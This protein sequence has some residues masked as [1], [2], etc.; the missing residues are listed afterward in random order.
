MAQLLP[1]PLRRTH[2]QH[3]TNFGTAVGATDADNTDTLTYSLSGTD[4]GSFGIDTS[5]GQLKTSV[6]LDYEM[7]TSYS[8]T[9]GVSDGT[10][11]DS[12]TVT[13]NVTNVNE[14]PAFPAT[15]ATR[16]VA[17]NTAANTNIGA[18]VAAT[19]PDITATNT[20]A[21]PGDTTADAL[22]YSLSGTDAAS[23]DIVSTSGQL[24][25]KAALDYE[26]KTS[27]TV[28][29]TASD[30]ALSDTITVTINVIDV[31]ET[32]PDVPTA[33]TLEIVSGD[34]QSSEANQTLRNSLVVVVKDQNDDPLP[35][36][37]VEFSTAFDPDTGRSFGTVSPTTDVT[38]ADGQASTRLTLGRT[39]GVY[40]VKASVDGIAKTVT[41][42]ANATGTLNSKNYSIGKVTSEPINIH[43]GD[44]VD[45]TVRVSPIPDEEISAA[46]YVNFYL[47]SFA[48]GL[49]FDDTFKV[50]IPGSDNLYTYQTNSNGEA[51]ARLN[52]A[53]DAEIPD[54]EPNVPGKSFRVMVDFL[55]DNVNGT[56]FFS[57]GTSE[58]ISP[59]PIS[60]IVRVTEPETSEG[61][62]VE[63]NAGEVQGG[64]PQ[65]VVSEVETVEVDTDA[66]GV[67]IS[68][69]PSGVQTGAFEVTV[70]FTEAVTGFAQEDLSVTGTA[71]AIITAWV[72]YPDNTTYTAMITPT[73]SGK[74]VL[75][76]A[77][78]V[79]TDAADNP[80]TASETQT[81]VI[82]IPPPI[83][84]PSTWMPDANLRTAVQTSLSL[85]TDE[86]LT[87]AKMTDLTELKAAGRSISDITGIEHATNLTSARL[88][89]NQISS[90]SPLSG[91]T[92]LTKL[93]L[94]NNQISDI[95]S[96]SGLT[97]LTQLFLNDNDITDITPLSGLVNL[98]TLKLSEN[99]LTN[100]DANAQ[101]LITLQAAGATIDVPV[102]NVGGAPTLE[103]ETQLP[104]TLIPKT[105]ALLSNY[106]N[107]FNPETW[108]P[109][110]LSKPAKVTIAIYNMR[111]VV[112]G[113]I[114][115]E[116]QAAGI[117]HNRSHAAHWD[118]RNA[119]GE[120]VANGVYFYTLTAGDFTATRKMLIRK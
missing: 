9:V 41:F 30:T 7:K 1:A 84:E 48:V 101:T 67:S 105:S 15:T 113:E 106:P 4:S 80:N 76:I 60:F 66:P 25:T 77:A 55:V 89:N 118:G 102:D 39:A 57:D 119:F 96:L 17:E 38:D 31:N 86:T 63:E 98:E 43:Y 53:L 18:A 69:F 36:V 64:Q 46:Q 81:I 93:R 78:G 79:A 32:P 103:Q 85:A 3:N 13:I 47:E 33:T 42:T 114:K 14:A 68:G 5:N 107:P 62:A 111:G 71:N 21:D 22:T 110:Q 50:K 75:N 12:I 19:D 45:I 73:I 49:S 8:V 112:V 91:L 29:V 92:T 74:V 27:Y 108:I 58:G 23:F 37:T 61:Q 94:Q 65:T 44:S 52:V 72:S 28:T 34:R 11:S 117:Y 120:R 20:D 26:T 90:L 87:Q 54:L 82:E 10:D 16:S 97:N 95:S 109:Y 24:K 83:P 70:T 115:L 51:T 100:N 2:R 56:Q 6:A 116:H 99:P 104:A 88:A 35:G 59:D 40:T